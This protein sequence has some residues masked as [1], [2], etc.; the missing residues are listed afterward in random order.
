MA[1][2]WNVGADLD[3]PEH[4]SC[5]QTEAITGTALQLETYERWAFVKTVIGYQ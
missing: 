1:T 4:I 2:L 3:L 5:P